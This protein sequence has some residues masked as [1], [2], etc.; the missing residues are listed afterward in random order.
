MLIYNDFTVLADCGSDLLSP[1]SRQA[2]ATFN[3]YADIAE[4]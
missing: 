1:F 4:K 3:F 2:V